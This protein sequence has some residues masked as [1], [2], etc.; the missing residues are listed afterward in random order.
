MEKVV[1]LHHK[2]A[3]EL[4]SV[5]EE[6]YNILRHI[7]Y[8]QPL[9]RRALAGMLET[10]ERVVRTQVD[11]L[12]SAGLVDF[13][14]LGMTV[15]REGEEI[16]ADLAEYIRL[17]RGLTSLEEE[18]AQKLS[19][20]QVI[21]IPGDSGVDDTV[22]RE[23]G[24][25]A[26][27]LVYKHLGQ[28]MTI[29]VS[30][31]STTAMMAEAINF[32]EPTT[33]VVPARGG[34]GERVEYQANTIAAVIATKLGGRYRLLHVKDAISEEV[35]EFILAGDAAILE[36]SNIIKHADILVHGIGQAAKMAASRGLDES[37]VAEI[38][39]KGAVGEAL[40]QYCDLQ[41]KI[42]YSTS[43]VGVRL[44]GLEDIGVVIAVAGG[45]K[46]AEALVAVANAGGQ[47][48]LITDEAAAREVQTIINIKHK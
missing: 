8:A 38:A 40:G 12:K 1:Q 35:L 14:P 32:T 18:I 46:K 2:I 37:V 25:A 43:S 10:G 24:R 5:I 20:K 42:V 23:M 16:L 28:N 13:S 44:D 45:R 31:G 7:Q 11:F 19:V 39:G 36:L 27:S 4:I 17:L 29:A 22:Q 9:G 3:P 48:I 30:G 6:R 26:A 33:T 41:G 47:D 34:L 21:I 15:T